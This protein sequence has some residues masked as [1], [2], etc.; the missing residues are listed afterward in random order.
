MP[1]CVILKTVCSFKS[2]LFALTQCEN[3][4]AYLWNYAVSVDEQVV[5]DIGLIYI[6]KIRMNQN[7]D[8]ILE[9]A[10]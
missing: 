4:S 10:D 8:V 7:R 1:I 2:S 6:R 3:L 5:E 9:C